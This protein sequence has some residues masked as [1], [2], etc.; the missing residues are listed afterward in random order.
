MLLKIADK[1]LKLHQGLLT[2]KKSETC[3]TRYLRMDQVKSIGRPYHF[4]L[5]KGCLPQILL[6]PFLNTLPHM[7]MS[8]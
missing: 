7:I 5:F 6:G 1:F 3:G 2:Y 4:K 8:T